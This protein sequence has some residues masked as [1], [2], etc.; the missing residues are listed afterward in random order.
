MNSDASDGSAMKMGRALCFLF[1]VLG[2]VLLCSGLE[3]A[4]PP[5]RPNIL[6]ILMD[7]LRWDEMDYPFVKD[8]TSS[9]LRAMAR[10]SQMRS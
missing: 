5:E 9:G 6:F 4:P 2:C 7:D 8:Q 10:A 1:T 3:A